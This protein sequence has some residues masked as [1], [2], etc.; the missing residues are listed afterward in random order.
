MSLS[1][2][3]YAVINP[4]KQLICWIVNQSKLV[5]ALHTPVSALEVGQF[6][7]KAL[8]YLKD[9]HTSQQHLFDLLMLTYCLALQFLFCDHQISAVLYIFS[10]LSVKVM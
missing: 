6:S 4:T 3:D 1:A 9:S 10:G 8:D 7:S 5:E 2:A